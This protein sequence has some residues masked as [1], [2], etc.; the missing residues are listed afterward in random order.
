[1]EKD[2]ENENNNIRT[3]VPPE[4]ILADE[5]I[6]ERSVK[7]SPQ[8]MSFNIQKIPE[9]STPKRVDGT[10]PVP[11]SNGLDAIDLNIV[12]LESTSDVRL[13]ER[14]RSSPSIQV[15]HYNV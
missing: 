6:E 10:N 5:N 12:N 14:A 2:E 9:V 11:L 1:M 7:K 4:A 3:L 13:D 8:Q 15:N